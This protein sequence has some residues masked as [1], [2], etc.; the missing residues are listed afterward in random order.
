MLSSDSAMLV[1]DDDFSAQQNIQEILNDAGYKH[2]HV[3][4][5]GKQG[6]EKVRAA[7]AS[8]GMYKIVFLDWD[9]P[10]M[11]GLTFLKICRGEYGLKD[12]AI[13]MVTNY[14]D[15]KSLMLA[16]GC[17]ATT[18]MKKPI[19]TEALLHKIEHI[20]NWIDG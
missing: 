12:V 13:I 5:D 1:V 18:F 11:D 10:E 3:A 19:S 14:T 20:S 16:L 6:I 9:M 2:V 15:Q 8:G 17:G 4:N 7:E